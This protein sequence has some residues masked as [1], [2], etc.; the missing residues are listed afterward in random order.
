MGDT[1][2]LSPL[3]PGEG[4]VGAE[5]IVAEAIY[6][7]ICLAPA[8]GLLCGGR[9]L[10]AIRKT[11]VVA[12]AVVAVAISVASVVAVVAPLIPVVGGATAGVCELENQD[13]N[14]TARGSLIWRDSD[15]TVAFDE[16]NSVTVPIVA[17][18]VLV[19]VVAVVVVLV[20]AV[21]ASVIVV[22]ATKAVVHDLCTLRLGQGAVGR[23]G[24]VVEANDQ[25]LCGGV[26]DVAVSP[27][28][29]LNITKVD[30][31]IRG[32]GCG[33]NEC[34]CGKNRDDETK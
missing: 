20:V 11:G 21:A 24:A 27:M 15:V 2:H 19:A 28:G 12:V 8:Y 10:V 16:R 6:Y 4:V 17:V 25:A 26:C 32:C 22:A 1:K 5:G 31:V 30:G 9:E 29:R 3:S 7:A 13:A 34:Q 23:K 14:E 18:V 33:R